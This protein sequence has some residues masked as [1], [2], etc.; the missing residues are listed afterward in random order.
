MIG[1]SGYVTSWD[2]E[3]AGSPVAIVNGTTRKAINF[4]DDGLIVQPRI[5]TTSTGIKV[6]Y[7]GVSAAPTTPGVVTQELLDKSGLTWLISMK[8]LRGQVGTLTMV[9]AD[10]LSFGT[11]QGILTR[12]IDITPVDI[13]RDS[14]WVSLTWEMI[15]DWS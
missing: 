14:V 13:K 9:D 12:V 6:H 7:D 4:P 11:A 10:G 5:Y 15:G 8:A 2:P 1:T 3:P